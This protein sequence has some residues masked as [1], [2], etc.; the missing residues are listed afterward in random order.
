MQSCLLYRPL[1]RSHACVRFLQRKII[2]RQ[3]RFFLRLEHDWDYDSRERNSMVLMFH[4]IAKT[5]IPSIRRMRNMYEACVIGTRYRSLLSLRIDHRVCRSHEPKRP[6]RMLRPA[7]TPEES[8]LQWDSHTGG[9]LFLQTVQRALHGLR[10]RFSCRSTW[11]PSRFPSAFQ[12]SY[13]CAG[14]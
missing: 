7:A 12:S 3:R 8:L 6:G 2:N 14:W 11:L 9:W 5:D 13:R 4:S 1:G 10:S